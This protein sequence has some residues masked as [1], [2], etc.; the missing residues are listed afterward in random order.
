MGGPDR[1]DEYIDAR[2]DFIHNEVGCEYN[3]GFQSAIA[4]IWLIFCV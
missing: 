1:D 2:D 3:G 4:G